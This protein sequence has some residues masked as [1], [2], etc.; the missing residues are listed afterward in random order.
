MSA[1]DDDIPPGV[2]F[3]SEEAA[4]KW[5]AEA[6]AKLVS[7]T[8]VFTTFVHAIT[9]HAPPVRN[10]LELGSGPGFLAEYILSRCPA[11]ENYA[12]LDF[13]PHM[14]AMSRKRLDA[15]G[16]RVSFLQINF[17]EAG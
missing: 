14:L 6:E 13:S 15:F 10:A 12:L 16:H 8:N 17:K 5:A 7:R 11:I 4:R 1:S 2:D 3:L 9:A